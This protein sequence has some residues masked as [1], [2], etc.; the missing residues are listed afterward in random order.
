[1]QD[2]S[3]SADKSQEV[4]PSQEWHAPELITLDAA[5]AESGTTPGADGAVRS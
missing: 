3:V 1:M 4:V 2:F 5:D